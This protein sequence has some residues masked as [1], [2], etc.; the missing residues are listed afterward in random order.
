MNGDGLGDVLL[1]EPSPGDV[2][3]YLGDENGGFAQDV[4]IDVP[5]N[6]RGVAMGDVDGDCA[7]EIVA[8]GQMWFE[9]ARSNP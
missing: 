4:I 8:V 9:V 6:P 1:T 5:A 2:V 3:I 7:V